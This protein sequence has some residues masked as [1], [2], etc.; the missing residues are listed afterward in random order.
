MKTLALLRGSTCLVPHVLHARHWHQRLFGLLVL[1]RLAE[2]HGLLIEPCASI[3]TLGM[4]YPLDLLFLS[5]D[6]QVLG[7]R[8]NLAPWRAA[9]LRGARST[10]ELPAG[11]LAAIAPRTGE[12]LQ[13]REVPRLDQTQATSGGLP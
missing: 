8:E 5:R 4:R 7:W 2:G 10:L 3:H 12:R 1:P 9:S 6:G 13:W 11:S